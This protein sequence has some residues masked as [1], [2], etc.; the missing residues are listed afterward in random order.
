[1]PL[2]PSWLCMREYPGRR[3][4]ASELPPR[5]ADSSSLP[6]LLEEQGRELRQ[7]AAPDHP[8]VGAGRLDVR[9]ADAFGREPLLQL[10]VRVDEAILGAAGDPEQAQL[11][12]RAGT[13]LGKNGIELLAQAAGTE[14]ADPGEAVQGVQADEERFG[15]AHREAGDGTGAAVRG[16]AI[17]LLHFGEDFGEEGVAETVVVPL[18]EIRV[19]QA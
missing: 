18:A 8:G 14:G 10:A 17:G 3:W 1:E 5:R 7:V 9:E 6:S 19:A 16:H 2:V 12:V 13:E 15:A 11:L 4:P